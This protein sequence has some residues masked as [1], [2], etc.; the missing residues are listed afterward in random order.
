MKILTT[1]MTTSTMTSPTSEEGSEGEVAAIFRVEGV[2]QGVGYRWWT[3]SQA[4][5][6][7][8]QGEVRNLPDGS[9]EVTAF[10]PAEVL[11]RFSELLA[12]GPPA[13]L[14]TR[15]GQSTPKIDRHRQQGFIITE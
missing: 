8:V 9:V 4:D 14:V 15:I 11:S 13:A 1:T 10:A 3:K 5:K 12:E 7:G 6:L 2:V